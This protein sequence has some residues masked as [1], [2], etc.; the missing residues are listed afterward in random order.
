MKYIV[1]YEVPTA[2]GFWDTHSMEASD[3]YEVDEII[4]KIHDL[5][6][7]FLKLEY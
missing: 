3:T 7:H 6:Y 1:Y 4:D 5:G 2:N